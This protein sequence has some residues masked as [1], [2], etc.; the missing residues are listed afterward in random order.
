M[1]KHQLHQMAQFALNLARK[2]LEAK[3][4]KVKEVKCNQ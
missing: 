2:R 3:E 4:K 1:D